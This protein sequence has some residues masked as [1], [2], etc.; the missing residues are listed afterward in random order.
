MPKE[1]TM[2][3]T[4]LMSHKRL[5]GALDDADDARTPDLRDMDRI[6]FSSAFRR[7]QDKTQ[8]FPL[9]LSDYVRTRLTHSIE[10]SCVGRS[11]GAIVG[12]EV[13]SRH[14]LSS[15]LTPTN[16]GI[17]VGVACLA[18]DIGNPPFGHSGEDAIQHWFKTSDVAKALL[19]RMTSHEKS[20]LLNFEGNAQGFRIL[21]R[22]QNADARG[23]LQLTC[24]TLGAFTKYP[25]EA[26]IPYDKGL[27]AGASM[28]KHGF[29]QREVDLF[30]EVADTLGLLKRT[31]CPKS[32]A[33]HP[34]AFLVEAADDIC[35]RIIDFEDG[36]R[37]G[38]VT[39]SDA[40]DRLLAIIGG[41]AKATRLSRIHQPQDKVAYLRSKAIN[42]LTRES[43]EVFLENEAAILAGSY[44]EP[45]VSKIE[46]S[47][48]LEEIKKLSKERV[49]SVQEVVEVEAAGFEV[50]C[51]LLEYFVSAAT[52]F[53]E[54]GKDAS[55][56]SRKYLQLLPERYR[57]S[58]QDPYKRILRITD[59]IS[60]MTDSFAVSLYRKFTG[61]SIPGT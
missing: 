26:A 40:E 1:A 7:L 41:E 39:Y 15:L 54:N 47:A 32:W 43:A 16:F 51:G 53:A 45:L 35:Y 60:G 34:L 59:Y 48:E 21:S 42:R 20:D 23:G 12:K 28:K 58:E 25:R 13:V 8:V 52:D 24:S 6:L 11:L 2:D 14:K 5:G 4:K 29:F 46:H 3:W 19:S 18:H 27:S 57:K 30:Q 31:E 9:P 17:T 36:F 10:A 44:D 55:A 56:M 22:L 37:L 61:I 50:I 49:Y 38:H 33:R